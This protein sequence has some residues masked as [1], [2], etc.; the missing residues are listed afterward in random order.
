[1]VDFHVANLLNQSVDP[2]NETKETLSRNFP[3]LEDMK[4]RLEAE[5][6]QK[7]GPSDIQQAPPDSFPKPMTFH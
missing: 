3:S 5:H 2:S 1:M 6:I 4:A 7:A